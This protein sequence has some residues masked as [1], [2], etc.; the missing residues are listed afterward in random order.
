MKKAIAVVLL[1]LS[2]WFAPSIVLAGP[3]ADMK[4]TLGTTRQH[5]M[6]MLSEDDRAVLEMRHEEA[7]KSS[8]DLDVMLAAALKNEALRPIQPTLTQFRKVWEEFKLTRDQ[9][10][11]PMLYAGDRLKARFTAFTTQAP[12]FKKMNELLESLPQ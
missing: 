7:M 5:T 4:T 1:L 10:I 8:K 2:G 6:A 12:R 9:E 11:I 3:V